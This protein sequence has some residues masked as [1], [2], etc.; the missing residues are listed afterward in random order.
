MIDIIWTI[1]Y[2]LYG[3]S[4]DNEHLVNYITV[5]GRYALLRHELPKMLIFEPFFSFFSSR[6][7]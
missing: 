5:P 6:F 4:N 2:G 7:G 1:S 3:M